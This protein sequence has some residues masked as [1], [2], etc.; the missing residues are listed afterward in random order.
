M[1]GISST[2]KFLC[3]LRQAHGRQSVGLS[4]R[5]LINANGRRG[6]ELVIRANAA[7][8]VPGKLLDRRFALAFIAFEK[9]GDEQLFRQRVQLDAARLS[10][11]DN[12]RVIIE[13]D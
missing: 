9:A 8:A 1:T 12:L 5:D 13:V 3:A 7:D 10:H 2:V 11:A 4:T 6:S